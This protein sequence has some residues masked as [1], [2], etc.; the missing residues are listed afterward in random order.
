MNSDSESVVEAESLPRS[1]RSIRVAEKA[2]GLSLEEGR[3]EFDREF[4][5]QALNKNNWNKS[6]TAKDLRITRQGLINM[7]QRLQLQKG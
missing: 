2:K 5:L 7:I 6:Q 4:V 3:E 1:L